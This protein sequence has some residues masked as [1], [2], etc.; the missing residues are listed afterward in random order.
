MFYSR[1]ERYSIE[2]PLVSKVICLRA[3]WSHVM[4]RERVRE[5]ES[6]R[7]AREELRSAAVQDHSDIDEDQ[8]RE[9]IVEKIQSGEEILNPP[10]SS[11]HSIAA[12]FRDEIRSKL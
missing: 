2:I 8:A 1:P 7:E 12:E 4:S 9:T 6:V 3:I 10:G 5:P 11:S